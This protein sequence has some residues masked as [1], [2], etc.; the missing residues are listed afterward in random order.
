MAILYIGMTHEGLVAMPDPKLQGMTVRLQDLDGSNSTRTA[1][2]KM[3][4]D[5]IVGGADAKR[6]IEVAWPAMTTADI[7]TILQAISE[8]FFWVKYPDPYT[9][10]FRIS[11][12]YA[13]DR[14]AP[15]YNGE[16]PEGIL[17]EGLEVNFIER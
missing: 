2:G 16:S 13:G 15:I 11:A 8:P 17:W 4:R 10:D 3:V 14:T 5:R 7:S 1:S 9:G 12:F 6:K